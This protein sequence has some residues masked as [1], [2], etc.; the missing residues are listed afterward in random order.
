ML[1][2][3]GHEVDECQSTC[4]ELKVSTGRGRKT[5]AFEMVAKISGN[6]VKDV[7]A[8]YK[9]CRNYLILAQEMPGTLFRLASEP[10]S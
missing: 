6:T 3:H 9:K 8:D 2:F 10:R 1:L 5:G 4:S 7:K